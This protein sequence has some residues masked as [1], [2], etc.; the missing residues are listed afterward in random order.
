MS[1]KYSKSIEAPYNFIP[2]NNEIFYPNWSKKVSHDIPF[3]DGE[4]GHIAIS[5]EAKSP[6]F[7]RNHSID[8]DKPSNEF[9]HHTNSNGAKEFYIPGSSIKGV[10]RSI[11]E[12]ISFSKIRVDEKKL[13]TFNS[14]RDMSLMS[15]LVG[16]A[17]GMGLLKFDEDGNAFLDD[18]GAARTIESKE[19]KKKFKNYALEDDL[20][21]KYKKI[22]PYSKITVAKYMKPIIKFGKEIG[23]KRDALYSDSQES[24]L[25]VM[26]RHIKKKHHEFVLVESDIVKKGIPIDSNSTLKKFKNVYFSDGDSETHKY[27]AF[28]K[29]Q[30][31]TVNGKKHGIPVFY[32]KTH[33]GKIK[34]LGLTQ[35]FKVSY[36]KTLLAAAKQNSDNSKLDL[37]E[38]L[39]GSE[40]KALELKGR[41]QFSHLK[42]TTQRF[43]KEKSELLSTPNP[44]YY[45][46]YIRQV[47]IDIN[48]VKS[49]KTLMDKDS[50]IAGYKVYP[51]QDK[52]QSYPLANTKENAKQLSHF[53][54]LES[55]TLFKG[56]LRFHNL[57]KVEIGALLSAITFHNQDKKYMHNIGMAKALGYGKVSIELSNFKY[58]KYSIKE[59]IQAF[60]DEMNSWEGKEYVRWQDSIQ[61]KELFSMHNNDKAKSLHYQML[62]KNEFHQDKKDKKYLHRHSIQNSIFK[63]TAQKKLDKSTS[64]KEISIEDIYKKYNDNVLIVIGALKGGQLDKFSYSKKELVAKL[65][66]YIQNDEKLSTSQKKKDIERREY[67]KSFT[68]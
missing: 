7:V 66:Q 44:S 35:L 20:F 15:T 4:S 21:E 54:P 41:V 8:K 62:S 10:I 58:M 14:V 17:N 51:L 60:E 19:I 45:P 27:G 49:Y 64:R 9:C 11:L 1:E 12:V 48:G 24:A 39:F 37:A 52:T 30:L 67:L 2:L 63:G 50:I 43:E 29:K 23:K 31:Q 36:N 33:S 13:N 3:E 55:G 5:V 53:K 25:L 18:Y 68:F 40:K 22:E 32:T 56:S 6:I 57:K 28:W 26:T 16:T 59:Y 46:N 42:S 47:N 65:I 38:T 34:E 61:I